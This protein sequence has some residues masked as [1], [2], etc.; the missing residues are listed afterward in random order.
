M[1]VN[2]TTLFSSVEK[3]IYENKCYGKVCFMGLK[4]STSITS[5]FVLASALPP[6]IY[7]V[8][9]RFPLSIDSIH[10]LLTFYRGVILLR[11]MKE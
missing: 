1:S 11:E 10:S 3:A 5:N 7:T 8:R 9:I 6:Y 2:H 4:N